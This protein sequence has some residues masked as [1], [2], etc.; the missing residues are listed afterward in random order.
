MAHRKALRDYYQVLGLEPGAS[1]REVKQAYRAGVKR[2][3]PDQF[4]CDPRL[5]QG[6]EEKLKE[7]NEAYNALCGRGWAYRRLNAGQSPR[8]FRTNAGRTNG[9]TNGAASGPGANGAASGWQSD[10]WHAGVTGRAF[11]FQ[12]AYYRGR[13]A[14]ARAGATDHRDPYSAAFAAYEVGRR[15]TKATIRLWVIIIFVFS[16]LAYVN[17]FSALRG[18]SRYRV[19]TH[20]ASTAARTARPVPPASAVR[21]TSA[22]PMVTVVDG[23]TIDSCRLSVVTCPEKRA[24][25]PATSHR[26]GKAPGN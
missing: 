26:L 2:W 19:A 20:A 7:I 16:V 10:P 9:G 18:A 17:P 22:V 6:A 25:D 8:D 23:K 24:A 13:Q 11:R 15:S 4:N 5:E 12:S 21:D 3:H 14:K 1:L